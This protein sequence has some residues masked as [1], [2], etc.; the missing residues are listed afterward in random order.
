[1]DGKI[2]IVDDQ[3]VMLR[4]VK[5]ALEREGFVTV[6]AE[7]GAAAL[8][9][10]RREQPDLLILDLLLP[11]ADGIELCRRIRQEL[12]YITL[13][14]LIL[15]GRIEIEDKI[16][17]L[18][19]GA[20]EYVTKPVDPKEM[21]ARVKSLLRRN[22]LLRQ[23]AS[24]GI[25]LHT[26]AGS[27]S[28][29]GCIGAKGGSGATTIAANVAVSLAQRNHRV[30]ALELRPYFGT[31][32]DMLGVTP[33]GGLT[34]LAEMTANKITPPRLQSYLHRGPAGLAVLPGP[35]QLTEYRD[36]HP[37]QVKTLLDAALELADF[38]VLDLPHMPSIANR[39]ALRR[40][41]QVLLAVEPEPGSLQAA[42][43]QLALLN[44]WG[45]PSEAVHAVVVNRMGAEYGLALAEV[46]RALE[47]GNGAV[48]PA[49]PDLAARAVKTGQ[50]FVVFAPDSKAAQTL[51]ELAA[52]VNAYAAAR[53]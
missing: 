5:H 51:S 13:P 50:P 7:T 16:E 18:E 35:R 24:P 47:C 3:A 1:M 38:V 15:T 6:T 37:D 46:E 11:D 4:L 22:Q 39:A 34:H 53:G 52:T 49:V 14:I 19:A 10:L 12:S 41:H 33:N 25:S 29:I 44:A 31:L 36:I 23:D 45:V 30:I 27:G 9:C 21:V 20:D 2:L 17:A 26:P 40:C 32:S 43:A 42:Q 48:I 28:V 8:D